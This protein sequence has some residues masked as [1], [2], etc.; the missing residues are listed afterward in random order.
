M[1]TAFL[2][3]HSVLAAFTTATALTLTN[4]SPSFAIDF[5][6]FGFC[7]TFLDGGSVDG[8]LSVDG[9]GEFNNFDNF[10]SDTTQQPGDI[11]ITATE[12][13]ETNKRTYTVADFVSLDKGSTITDGLGGPSFAAYK[14]TFKSD[15][16][17]LATNRFEA[18]LPASYFSTPITTANFGNISPVPTAQL[19]YRATFGDGVAPRTDPDTITPVPWETDALSVIGSTILFG[20]GVWFKRKSANASKKDLG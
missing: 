1:I 11:I 20:C 16:L 18:Y 9:T 10:G 5:F 13:G 7:A 14:Y 6:K 4:A 3:K 17:P 19:E 12:I 8:F 2:N 15:G